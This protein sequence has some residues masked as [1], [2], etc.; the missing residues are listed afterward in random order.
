M[1]YSGRP[2]NELLGAL[3]GF[4][5]KLQGELK[6]SD[7]I[8][9]ATHALSHLKKRG[10]ERLTLFDWHQYAS[11][12]V[13]WYVHAYQAAPSTAYADP[14]THGDRPQRRE[15]FSDDAQSRRQ[16]VSRDRRQQ[17]DRQRRV[18]G[19]RPRA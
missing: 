8:S 15:R 14:R 17:R 4:L 16:P 6:Q 9:I 13:K 3:E 5:T 2:L 11:Q 7:A 1:A 10:E 18:G 19:V 12:M